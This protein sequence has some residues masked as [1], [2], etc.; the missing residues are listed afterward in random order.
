MKCCEAQGKLSLY[1][2]AELDES[3]LEQLEAHLAGC[4]SCRAELAA[5]RCV[6]AAANEVA[7]VEPPSGLKQAIYAALGSG[8]TTCGK[9][10]ESLSA[11]VDGELTVDQRQRVDEHISACTRCATEAQAMQALAVAARAV[12]DVEPPRSLRSRIAAATTGAKRVP[13]AAAFRRWL[14][15]ALAPRTVRWSVAAV[16]AGVVVAGVIL[17]TPSGREKARVA[18]VEHHMPAPIISQIDPKTAA[19][20][21]PAQ[22]ASAESQPTSA[23]V[24][25]VERRTRVARHV[26]APR[27]E[28]VAIVPPA[29]IPKPKPVAA[30]ELRSAP[31]PKPAD[32]APAPA[33]APKPVAEE[34]VEVATVPAPAPEIK[35]ERSTADRPTLIRV[36]AAPVIEQQDPE[37]WARQLRAQA[38][39]RGGRSGSR[40]MGLISARF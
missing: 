3:T 18:S 30:P 39:M 17:G 34:A 25:R 19:A 35:V 13:A 26:R 12:P 5:L 9:V 37:E 31:K 24:V 29:R 16:T 2:D 40:G 27:T 14:T 23:P 28:T 36:A 32:V 4:E 11:Y 6:V 8:R 22:L 33:P 38:A 7:Q 21:K 15:D 1:L 20:P 10:R